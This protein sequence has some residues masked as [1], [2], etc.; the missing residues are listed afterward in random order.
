ML[1]ATS[2]ATATRRDERRGRQPWCFYYATGA[3]DRHVLSGSQHR[4]SR[5]GTSRLTKQ[6]PPPFRAP[7]QESI[8]QGPRGAAAASSPPR[9]RSRPMS[10]PGPV[11]SMPI[12]L[13]N[14]SSLTRY[15]QVDDGPLIPRRSR[16]TR[17]SLTRNVFERVEDRRV[18]RRLHAVERQRDFR[19]ETRQRIL[20]AERRRGECPRA[21]RRPAPGDRATRDRSET[22]SR[23]VAAARAA[24]SPASLDERAPAG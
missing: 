2:A 8:E 9:R 16:S 11:S 4:S 6:I 1:A 15:V 19:R 3:E 14:G 12:W 23:P 18:D 5:T 20:A 22:A 24:P 13:R 21:G 7:A 17:P 10:G